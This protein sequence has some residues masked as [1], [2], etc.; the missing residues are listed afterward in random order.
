MGRSIRG[1]P[2]GRSFLIRGSADT[3]GRTHKGASRPQ[4]VKAAEGSGFALGWTALSYLLV[5]KATVHLKR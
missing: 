2:K 1:S 3:A 5:H 4:P